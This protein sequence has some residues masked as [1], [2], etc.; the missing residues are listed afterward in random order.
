MLL[1][2]P[3]GPHLGAA[4]RFDPRA[5]A[6]IF[7]SRSFRSSCFGYFGHM[8][9]LYGFWAFVPV[10][11]V[12]HAAMQTE[13]DINI[14]LWTS[15]IIAAGF[16]GCAAGGWLSLRVGSARV[17]GAQLAASGA[18]C[19]V[20]PLMFSVPTPVLLGFLLFWGIVVVGDSPQFSAL[21]AR[22]APRSLVGSA[23][24]IGNCI[25]FA[26]TIASIQL[27]NALAESVPPAWLFVALAPGPLLG[28][29]AMRPLLG[30]DPD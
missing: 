29:I 27:L 15:L 6:I 28:L 7:R 20:S 2:V 22:Y 10:A 19:L 25:G 24:T 4:A 17:A 30:A 21:N 18:C 12:A 3:D 11:L 9:E 26:I 23:L 1:L 13:A 16:I 5:I 8:W 14:S